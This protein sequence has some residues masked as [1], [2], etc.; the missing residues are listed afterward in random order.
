MR[1]SNKVVAIIL[2]AG[3]SQRI[4]EDKLFYPILNRPLLFWTL[5]VFQK[6]HLIDSIVLVLNKDN[7]E[8]GKELVNKFGFSK[9][10]QI[11]LGGLRRQ[12]SVREGLKHLP[13]C[14]WVVIHDGCRPCLS[15]E[16]IERGLELA[17]RHK[18]AVPAV[19]IKETVKVVEGEFIKSTPERRKLWVAQTPQ[20]FCV[21]II[22]KAYE[23]SQEASDDS[24]LVEMLGY[25]VPIYFGSYENI[26]VTTPE[27]LAIAELWLKRRAGEGGAGI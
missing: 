18:A 11:C 24:S 23:I 15:P 6:S 7:W 25:P 3:K 12:D 20:I 9:V 16:I 13:P 17:Q 14:H 2:A 1:E 22:K 27:D 8:K 10:E 21:E 4:G 26:K 19:P 5:N